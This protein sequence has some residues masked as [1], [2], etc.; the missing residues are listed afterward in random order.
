MIFRD[1]FVG[2]IIYEAMFWNEHSTKFKGA[3]HLKS[4]AVYMWWIFHCL[5]DVSVVEVA[6]VQ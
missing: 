6:A 1:N 2:P 3:K 5:I 4:R